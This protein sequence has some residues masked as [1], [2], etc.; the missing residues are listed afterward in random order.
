MSPGITLSV[1]WW[2][3]WGLDQQRDLFWWRYRLGF[4][5]VA[6]ECADTLSAYRKL[7]VA[8]EARVHQDER[9]R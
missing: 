9:V 5:T 6:L 4:L 2:R 8:I 7:R 1:H 3:G